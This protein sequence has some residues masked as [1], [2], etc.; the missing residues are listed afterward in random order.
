MDEHV[1]RDRDTTV[2]WPTGQMEYL[3]EAECSCGWFVS[4]AMP[5]Q[6]YDAAQDHMVETGAVWP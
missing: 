3:Y 1:I 4:E 5:M 2:S 6:R